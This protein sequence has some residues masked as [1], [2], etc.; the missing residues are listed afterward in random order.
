MTFEEKI[1][2][3]INTTYMGIGDKDQTAHKAELIKQAVLE[4]IESL[5]LPETYIPKG[6]GYNIA[7]DDLSARFG[8]VEK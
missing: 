4:G 2:E 5:R 1:K 3:I 6:Q 8:K 7:L